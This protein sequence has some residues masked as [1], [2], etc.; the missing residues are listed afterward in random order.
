MLGTE[1]AFKMD[2]GKVLTMD[3]MMARANELKSRAGIRI[4]DEQLGDVPF[5]A[6]SWRAGYVLSARSAGISEKQIRD[7]GRW[8]SDGGPAPYTFTSKEAFRAASTAMAETR[9]ADA[10]VKVFHMGAFSSSMAVFEAAEE[11]GC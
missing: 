2:N 4:L 5:R 1:P 6:A 10:D 7:T 9:R 8:R 11:W 3:F